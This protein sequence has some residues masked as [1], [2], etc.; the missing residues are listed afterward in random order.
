MA[1]TVGIGSILVVVC[2]AIAWGGLA[3]KTAGNALSDA[4]SSI[5]GFILGNPPGARSS[6][7]SYSIFGG[8]A[9]SPQ[10]LLNEYRN[11]T[12]KER[13]SFPS[14]YLPT[15]DVARYPTPAINQPSLPL[16]GIGRLLAE[17]NIP[18]AGLNG[19]LREA[20][21]GGEQLFLGIGLIALVLVQRYRRR[22]SREVFY[23][24]VGSIFMLA[25][26]TVLPN[27]SV[28]YGV[29]RAFQEALI[30]IAPLFVIGSV[31]AFQP[32]GERWASRIATVICVVIFISTIGLLPQ[33]TG[34]YPAQLNLNNSGLYYDLYYVHP[35]EVTAVNWLAHQPDVSSV[36][37]NGV[38]AENITYKYAFASPSDVTGSEIIADYYPTLVTRSSWVILG[39]TTIH[40]GQA[41]ADYNSDLL[42]YVYPTELLRRTKNLVYSNGGA[43]IYK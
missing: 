35:Q 32:L 9:Q 3:T 1:Q 25:L 41:T 18:V 11:E 14:I 26:I 4:E 34:G 13:A 6:D 37:A 36:L 8:K 27:L 33:I 22:M 28:D 16:T 10:T 2:I 24:C 12:M 43:Q 20:A 42:T 15:S 5:S 29:L 31:T 7:V 39:Y 38:Q 30:L 19:A 40:T 23:L 17:A 21:A